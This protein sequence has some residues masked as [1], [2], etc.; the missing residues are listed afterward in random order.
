MSSQSTDRPEEVTHYWLP[1]SVKETGNHFDSVR[2]QVFVLANAYDLAVR[3]HQRLLKWLVLLGC[4][5]MATAIAS[6]TLSP[7]VL[8]ARTVH[9]IITA[10]LDIPVLYA[11]LVFSLVLTLAA[12]TAII[13]A[14]FIHKPLNVV[15]LRKVWWIV[16]GLSDQSGTLLFDASDIAP[17]TQVRFSD[18]SHVYL[19]KL[20]EGLQ[21]TKTGLDEE[22]KLLSILDELTA[23][24]ETKESRGFSTTALEENGVFTKAVLDLLA[25]LEQGQPLLGELS[26]PSTSRNGA[27]LQR[28]LIES[29]REDAARFLESLRTA[30]S[31]IDKSVTPF[32]TNLEWSIEA[33][34]RHFTKIQSDL[35]ERWFG[36]LQVTAEP[37]TLSTLTNEYLVSQDTLDKISYTI[38]PHTVELLTWRDRSASLYT[39]QSAIDRLEV[40]AGNSVTDEEATLRR[41]LANRLQQAESARQSFSDEYNR[42][43]HRLE[44]E[45]RMHDV[46][47]N[48]YKDMSQETSLQLRRSRDELPRLKYTI[49]EAK[50]SGCV[51][52]LRAAHNDHLTVQ[53]RI[54]LLEDELSSVSQERT[55]H[56]QNAKI[57]R[58]QASL[59]KVELENR[60]QA[61]QS[62]VEREIETD[63][64]SASDNVQSIRRPLDH[65]YNLRDEQLLALKRVLDVIVNQEPELHLE[66]F[67]A[68]AE[69]LESAKAQAVS[70]V[71]ALRVERQT[72]LAQIEHFTLPNITEHDSIVVY[73]PF[74]LAELEARRGTKAVALPPLVISRKRDPPKV[75][76]MYEVLTFPSSPE[77]QCVSDAVSCRSEVFATYQPLRFDSLNVK[78]W[79]DE[80]D[81]LVFEGT[82]TLPYASRLK[83]HYGLDGIAERCSIT[84][85]R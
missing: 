16:Y 11:Y 70:Q 72:I 81:R 63:I 62:E 38:S 56:Q 41:A 10:G 73:I 37:T 30:R 2:E 20:V 3:D 33:I 69:H 53:S 39:L 51:V 1:S 52:R 9:V 15:S 46:E 83:E 5:L 58:N 26:Q 31:E 82:I 42:K 43:I 54:A 66:S 19:E 25:D 7:L 35:N 48:R 59:E 14:C 44:Q 36:N 60:V 17:M 74:W 71:E 67:T 50:L 8:D 21:A 85:D 65:L 80:I 12:C 22:P 40:S 34:D 23:L 13:Y 27:Y 64:Q 29:A 6:L 32:T 61:L 18:V 28:E 49:S 78:T 47:A 77:L 76:R 79:A 75:R 68:R 45:A 57:L 24:A 55:S 4:A 84:S